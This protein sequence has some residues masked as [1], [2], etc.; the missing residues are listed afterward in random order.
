MWLIMGKE[1]IK[2]SKGEIS[3]K[4]SGEWMLSR[5]DKRRESSTNDDSYRLTCFKDKV[6]YNRIFNHGVQK[7]NASHWA[8]HSICNIIKNKYFLK[9]KFMFMS[10]DELPY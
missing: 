2:P 7:E 10:L 5:T 9:H 4:K 3:G 6:C 1:V 8:D